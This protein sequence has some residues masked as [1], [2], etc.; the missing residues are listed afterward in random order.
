[1]GRKSKIALGSCVALAAAL[2]AFA[3][4]DDPHRRT[5]PEDAVRGGGACVAEAGTLPVPNCSN[6]ENSC[7]LSPGCAIDEAQCGSKSTCLPM[8][9]NKGKTVLDFRMR[10]LNIAAP[11]AL[12]ADF[13]QSTVVNLNIDLDAKA[14]AETGKGLFTWLL[15]ID[16]AN[17][18][19][20]TG[21]APPP[22]DPTG[23]GYCFA[24]F[25]IGG[26][27]VE[28]LTTKIAFEGNTFKSTEGG[29][30]VNI[31][32]FLNEQ[33]ASAILL[34][35]SGARLEGITISEDTNCIGAF[36]PLG[37]DPSCVE[38]RSICPKWN[39]NASLGGYITLE[40]ADAVK[41]RDL[42]N[43]SLC[44]FLAQSSELVCPRDAQGKI[45]FKGDYCSTTNAAGGCQDS[46]WL[47]ATFA[48]SAV[49]IFDGQGTVPGCSGATTGDAGTEDAGSD[50]G[51]DASD[52]G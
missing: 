28:P 45:V 40:E 50:A 39:T 51:V 21:G 44:S 29:K 10:R 37:L 3:C 19:L 4:S 6:P 8:G 24:N 14:C 30:K 35:I 48:A 12:A 42:N 20:V 15:R 46:V 27:K 13:I 1:M 25:D 31:P 26:V 23:Q 33:L 16:R 38:D 18:T 32:I 41:I 34:P 9:D 52:G 49:K 47:A 5:S 43:K 17:N 22:T 2:V 11:P 7:V 36:N